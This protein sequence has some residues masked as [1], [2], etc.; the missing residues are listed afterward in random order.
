MPVLV[1]DSNKALVVVSVQ[2]SNMSH[3]MAVQVQDNDTCKSYS[4][5]SLIVVPVQ[6]SNKLHMAVPVQDNA[7]A[8]LVKNNVFRYLV[9]I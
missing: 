7:K 4:N 5:K 6:D 2:D 3:M 9:P 1:Q 8:Q